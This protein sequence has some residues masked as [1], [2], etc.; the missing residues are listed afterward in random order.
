MEFTTLRTTI[1]YYF[2]FRCTE[3]DI[4]KLRN[5]PRI[6]ILAVY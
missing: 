1:A 5:N 2:S 4:Y 6:S 3:T